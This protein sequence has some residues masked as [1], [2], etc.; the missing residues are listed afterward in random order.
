M[1]V[2]ISVFF[3]YFVQFTSD[4]KLTDSQMK[5]GWRVC[6]KCK[7]Y[8]TRLHVALLHSCACKMTTNLKNSRTSSFDLHQAT[9]PSLQEPITVEYVEGTLYVLIVMRDIDKYTHHLHSVIKTPYQF[10]H[11]HNATYRCYW[12]L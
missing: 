1:V 6:Y 8:V 5:L 11:V 3:V 10:V 4:A 9:P 7:Y 12:K 2:M